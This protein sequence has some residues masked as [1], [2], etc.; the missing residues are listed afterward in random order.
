MKYL[1][2]IVALLY[3]VFPHDLVPDLLIGPGWLDDLGV[4]ALAWWWAARLRRGYQ[5]GNGA[6]GS[7]SG[8]HRPSDAGGQAKE[9]PFQEDDPYHILGVE[10]GASKAEIKAVY[11]KLAAQYHPDKVQ[12]LGREFQ[13]LAHKTFVAIQKAYDLV[14]K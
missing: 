10:K 13:E 14:M 9:E 11:K 5:T 8:R 12:H 6:R 4:M 2:W 3:F 1:P 7:A